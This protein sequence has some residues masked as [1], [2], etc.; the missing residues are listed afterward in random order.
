M[1][2]LNKEAFVKK[3]PVLALRVIASSVDPLRK[4]LARFGVW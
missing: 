2:I 4:R 3:I 1:G